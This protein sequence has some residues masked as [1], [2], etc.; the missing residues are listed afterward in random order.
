MIIGVPKEI[1]TRENRVSMT[2]EGIK[3]LVDLGHTVLLETNAGSGSGFEDKAYRKA[4]AVIE[5]NTRD[6]WAGADMVV[7]VKEPIFTEYDYFRPGLIIF[8]Y[9]HL[10]ANLDLTQRLL[11]DRVTAIAYETIEPDDGTLPLLQPMSEIAGKIGAQEAAVLLEH[12]NGGKGVLMGGA[13]G[14][15]PAR[16]LVLGGGISGKAA[17]RVAMGMGADVTILDVNKA[18]LERLGREF[19]ENCSVMYSSPEVIKKFLP[20]TDIVIGCVLIHGAKSPRVI[21]R[22]M[23]EL[24]EPG[25]ILVDIAIDQGGC[26]ETSRPTTHDDPVFVIDGILHYCV[27]NMPGAVPRTSTLAL[28]N[29]TMPWVLKIAGGKLFET[30]KTDGALFKGVNTVGGCLTHEPVA[31]AFD[32]SYT[33]LVKITGQR[34]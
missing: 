24:M 5:A 31:R 3:K 2:P 14:V 30:I 34:K 20:E 1:K 23:L 18:C 8:T 22:E 4:G 15:A 11:V 6:V 17:A 28:S 10:A 26:F 29:A 19:N 7:K 13:T 32:L 27:A 33:P 21:T 25:S 9:L 12:H 16:V